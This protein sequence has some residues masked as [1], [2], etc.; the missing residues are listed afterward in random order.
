MAWLSNPWPWYVGGPLIGLLVPLLLWIG[1]RTFGVS[2]SLRHVCAA[3]CPGRS[4]YLN[5]DWK[6]KGLWNL[7]FVAGITL[8]GFIAATA[9][10]NPH[11][12][13]LSEATRSDLGALGITNFD[14]IAP[15]ELFSWEGLASIPGFTILVIGGFLVGFGARWA[16]G[17]TSG[18]AIMGFAN[19]QLSS[20]IAVIGFFIGGLGATYFLLPLI[21]A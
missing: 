14:S 4:Q 7:F 21:L 15:T 17:C 16:N 18:H 3:T 1:N 6:G 8:G 10:A 2:S 9:L 13:Q 20:L 12:F 11:A 5:Y 19:F